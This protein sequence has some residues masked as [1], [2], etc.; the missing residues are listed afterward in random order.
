VVMAAVQGATPKQKQQR[1]DNEGMDTIHEIVENLRWEMNSKLD[2]EIDHLVK[3][4][5]RIDEILATIWHDVAAVQLKVHQAVNALDGRIDITSEA[6]A[7][8]QERLNMAQKSLNDRCEHM[9]RGLQKALGIS[10]T[11]NDATFGE[12]RRK[13]SSGKI[14]CDSDQGANDLNGRLI[15]GPIHWCRPEQ[16]TRDGTRASI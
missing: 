4:A 16:C 10:L 13:M 2:I 7:A 14:L 3:D 6:V 12:A 8:T 1:Q 15:R 11:R 9:A 5:R